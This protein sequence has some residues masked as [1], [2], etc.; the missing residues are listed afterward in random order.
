M[1]VCEFGILTGLLL[2]T[3]NGTAEILGDRKGKNYHDFIHIH[4]FVHV[5]PLLDTKF[6]GLQP[7]HKINA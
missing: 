5:L 7:N 6:H 4:T 2:H 1:A 3:E